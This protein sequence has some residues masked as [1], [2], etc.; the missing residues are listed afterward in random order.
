MYA[1]VEAFY[2]GFNTPE[3]SATSLVLDCIPMHGE[4]A[5]GGSCHKSKPQKVAR[6]A[7]GPC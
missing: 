4:V 7:R 6:A 1:G 5:V 2:L 3:A